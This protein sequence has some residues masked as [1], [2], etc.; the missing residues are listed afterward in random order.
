MESEITKNVKNFYEEQPFN[1]Y[2]SLTEAVSHIK[3]NPIHAYPDLNRVLSLKKTK[4]LMEF[5]CGTGWFTNASA[6]H[7]SKSVTAVDLSHSA[8]KRAKE[9][10]EILGTSKDITFVESDLFDFITTNSVDLV[11]SIGVLHH[12][13][14]ARDAF[15]HIQKFVL[16]KGFIFVG[17]YH[18]F[19]RKVFLK[20]FQDILE[21][22][23]E[24]AAFLRFKSLNFSYTDDTFLRS[25]FRDQVLHPNETLHTLEEVLEWLDESGFTLQS[26]SINRFEKFK[27]LTDLIQIEKEYEE[28]S[29]RKN[30]VENCFFP[31]FFT[32]LAQKT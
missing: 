16:K 3:K 21:K 26:T 23:G 4:L 22:E 20:L 13:R 27:N 14:N 25:R 24:D 32:I 10:A 8:I 11:V 5:G 12:T 1:Y 30:H 17:L 2:G 6:Y 29:F 15:K 31:G 9:M 18:L 7:Y 28:I 19:G